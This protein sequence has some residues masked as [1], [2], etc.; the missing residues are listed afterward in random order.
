MKDPAPFRHRV[1]EAGEVGEGEGF[2]AADGIETGAGQ[3][4][5]GG[6][7]GDAGDGRQGL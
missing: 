7:A 3:R 1:G 6:F 4:G 5:G 2:A